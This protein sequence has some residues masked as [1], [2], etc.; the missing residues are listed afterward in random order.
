MFGLVYKNTTVRN[1]RIDLPASKSISN[2]ALILNAF[3]KNSI[4]LNNLSLADD[5]Q[6]MNW[7]LNTNET[8]LNLKNAGTCMRFLTAYFATQNNKEISLLCSN[9]MK[10]RPIANLVN[11]LQNLD[12]DITYLEQ[13]NIP[14]LLIKGKLILG[15]KITIDAS[16]SSQFI[17]ALMLIAPF[18]QNGLTIELTGN[19]ASFDYIK[20][21]ALLMEQFGLNVT[22]NSN[23]ITIKNQTNTAPIKEF[24]IENDWS[25]AA[26]WYLTC[27][28]NNQIAITLNNL[29][30]NSIQGD[31]ITAKLFEQLGIITKSID[32]NLI[33]Q[34]Q[35]E[36]NSTCYF[37]LSNCIDLAPALTV[38]CASL[39]INATV[40]GLKNLVIKESNRLEAIV[41][42][43]KKIGY[44]VSNNN[45][46]IFIHQ[47]SSIDFN[48]T[49]KINTYD[50]HRIAMAFAPLALKFNNISLDNLHVVKKS[51][52]N[53]FTELAKVGVETITL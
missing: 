22:L 45:N 3:Y 50:D 33:I 38:A 52:P 41:T 48:K 18:I 16:E 42:E 25:S 27:C 44:N 20:M 51:Y 30:T 14:P 12:A 17:T 21:T 36:A 37:D 53:F 8:Q 24:T 40:T 46:T 9:R 31:N 35:L 29:S 15:K 49:V 6:L 28:L 1:I 4:T 2:R 5:T 7:A 13:K 23:I 19:I 39:N 26:F 32:N 10:Q 47:T 34:K 11:A 43:L